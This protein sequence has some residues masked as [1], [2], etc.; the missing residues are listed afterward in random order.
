MLSWMLGAKRIGQSPGKIQRVPIVIAMGEGNGL[1]PEPPVSTGP[2][3]WRKPSLN[4]QVW[5]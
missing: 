4:R 1:G 2:A 5:S 3:G